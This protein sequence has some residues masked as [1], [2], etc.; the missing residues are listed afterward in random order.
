MLGIGVAFAAVP[1]LSLYMPDLVNQVQ[2][3]SLILNGV[4]AFFSLIGFARAGYVDWKRGGLLA[5]ITTASAPVGSSLARLVTPGELWTAYFI[6]VAF[7]CWSLTR[8]QPQKNKKKN[9]KLALALAVPISIVSSFIGV[10]PGFLLVPALMFSGFNARSAA[11]MN[12]LAVTPSSFSAAAP[13]WPHMQF[14][15]ALAVP[16]IVAGAI[17]SLVGARLATTHVPEDYLRY[18]LLVVVIAASLY[19][20]AQF[21]R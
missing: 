12:S 16:L 20:I 11:A 18:V 5:A 4:T 3:L 15:A 9:F 17:G 1:F 7:L 14:D 2:P 19:R 21:L 13:H 10:G 6:A 8:P